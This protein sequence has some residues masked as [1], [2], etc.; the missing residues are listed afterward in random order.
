MKGVNLKWDEGQ[1]VPSSQASA[2]RT[3]G[4][5]GAC[6]EALQHVLFGQRLQLLQEHLMAVAVA[7]SQ[8]QHGCLLLILRPN[9]AHACWCE[10][11]QMARR[12]CE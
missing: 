11:L 1:E 10:R 9:P 7:A 5:G 8:G 6:L 2:G 12:C 3:G 4:G